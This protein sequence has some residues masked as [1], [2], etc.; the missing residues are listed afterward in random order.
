[1]PQRYAVHDKSSE[2]LLLLYS[3][4]Y[5]MPL[6]LL[7]IFAIYIRT[8]PFVHSVRSLEETSRK[9]EEEK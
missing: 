7:T 9:K 2:L 6:P 3:I 4:C 1:M 5:E 8:A